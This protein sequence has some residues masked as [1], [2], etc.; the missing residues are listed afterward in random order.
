MDAFQWVTGITSLISFGIQLFDLFPRFRENRQRILFLSFGLFLGSIF[1]AIDSSSIKIVIQFSGFVLLITAL[2][3]ALVGLAFIG[4]LTS[5]TERRA[6]TLGICFA[7]SMGYLIILFFGSLFNGAIE[8]PKIEMQ[9]IT[10]TELLFLSEKAV[11]HKNYERAIMHLNTLHGRIANDD[12]RI[13]NIEQR[14][15]EI[16]QLE[17]SESK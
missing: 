8:N 11:E 1:R 3:I 13:K 10:S 4:A 14:I 2:T 12:Q 7:G 9:K 5:D 15:V 17:L 6:T 16:K